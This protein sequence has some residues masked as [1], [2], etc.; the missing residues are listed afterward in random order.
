MN[1][2]EAMKPTGKELFQQAVKN[3]NGAQSA[4]ESRVAGV[5][6]TLPE[7]NQQVWL[8]AAGVPLLTA[9]LSAGGYRVR[10]WSDLKPIQKQ[11]MM[12]AYRSF[13]VISKRGDA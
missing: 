4:F 3:M 5:F 7:I 11:N 2:A 9:N 8:K 13:L 10:T 6:A 1:T 12:A